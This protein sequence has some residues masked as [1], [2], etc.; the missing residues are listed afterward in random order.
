MSCPRSSDYT[1]LLEFV[2]VRLEEFS[3]CVSGITLAVFL[4]GARVGFVLP[5]ALIQIFEVDLIV[6]Q[7]SLEYR[8]FLKQ[9]VV[10]VRKV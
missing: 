2:Y 1:D 10:S 9:V 3:R 6:D 4:F 8:V 5:G 7:A